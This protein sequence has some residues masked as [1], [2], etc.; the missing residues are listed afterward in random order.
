MNDEEEWGEERIRDDNKQDG[1][2]DP[3]EYAQPRPRINMVGICSAG[4]GSFWR[5]IIP[6]RT[7]GTR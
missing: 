1:D 3:A 4:K 7:G 2:L 5:R 6:P